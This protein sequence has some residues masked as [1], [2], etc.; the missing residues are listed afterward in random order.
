MGETHY[1][2][3]MVE[4]MEPKAIA[5]AVEWMEALRETVGPD[6]EILVDAHARMDVASAIKAANAIEHV[7][8][9]W[10]ESRHTWKTTTHFA[11]Y[12]KPRVSRYA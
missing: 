7:D 3:N 10:F 2:A 4:R 11:K 9:V 5:D 12:A 6:Y 1:G 8:L